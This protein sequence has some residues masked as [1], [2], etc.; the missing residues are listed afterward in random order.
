METQEFFRATTFTR[1]DLKKHQDIEEFYR[2]GES[3]LHKSKK[4]RRIGV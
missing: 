4:E 3:S 2:G 1:R